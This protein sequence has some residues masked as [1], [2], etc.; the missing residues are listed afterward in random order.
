MLWIAGVSR[1]NPIRLW[2][3]RPTYPGTR[4]IGHQWAYLPDVAETMIRLLEKS[5]DLDT[6]AQPS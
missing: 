2:F 6:F 4:G 5:D 1:S 3:C